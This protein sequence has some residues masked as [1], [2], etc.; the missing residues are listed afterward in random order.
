VGPKYTQDMNQ[1]S[2]AL[3]QG[4]AAAGGGAIKNAA[5]PRAAAA[6]LARDVGVMSRDAVTGGGVWGRGLGEVVA[7]TG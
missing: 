5:L 4:G 2:F 7:V 6:A 1:G 3:A